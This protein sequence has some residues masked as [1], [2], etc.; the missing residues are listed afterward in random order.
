MLVSEQLQLPSDQI[1]LKW[2]RCGVPVVCI[3]LGRRAIIMC[4]CVAS[5]EAPGPPIESGWVTAA[6]LAAT[7]ATSA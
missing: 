6:N 4:A 2:L 7:E 3:A 1:A 5:L